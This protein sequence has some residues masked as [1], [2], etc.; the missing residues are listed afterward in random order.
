MGNIF[1]RR[2]SQGARFARGTLL[3]IYANGWLS[4]PLPRGLEEQYGESLFIDVPDLRAYNQHDL[5]HS[6]VELDHAAVEVDEKMHVQSGNVRDRRHPPSQQ[7]SVVLLSPVVP[8]PTD[9]KKK[10]MCLATWFGRIS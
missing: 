2:I 1:Q 6:T 9:I 8:L 5:L 4:D 10:R 7:T 3:R